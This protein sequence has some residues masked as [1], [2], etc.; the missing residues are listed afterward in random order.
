M[1]RLEVRLGL[2][3]GQG[4]GQ[5]KGYR[6]ALGTDWNTPLPMYFVL[7]LTYEV[8]ELGLV[9]KV[10]TKFKSF[11]HPVQWLAVFLVLAGQ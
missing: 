3:K 4:K 1:I 8:T 6:M 11:A 10:I 2:G 5:G 9:Q 7:L